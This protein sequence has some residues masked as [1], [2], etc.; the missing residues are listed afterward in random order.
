MP[1]KP[2]ADP[3]NESETQVRV[4][5]T[6]LVCKCPDGIWRRIKVDNDGCFVMAGEGQGGGAVTVQNW[7]ASY[8][9]NNW[10]TGFVV[11]G[12]VAVSNFPASFQVSNFPA[13]QAVTGTFWPAT[14]PVS[15]TFWQATQ[16]VSGPLTDAQLRAAAVPVSGTFWPATQPVSGTFWQATQ[17]VSIAASVAVT[18]TFWQATQPVSGPLTDA[19]LRAAAVP[20]SGAFFQATQPVSAAALPLPTGAAQDRPSSLCVTGTAASGSGVTITLPNVAGQFHYI[21]SI[22]ISAYNVAARTGGAT[23]VVCTTTNIPGSLAFTF[24]SA[25]A[26]GTTESQQVELGG[27]PLKSSVANTTTTIVCPATSNVIWRVTAFYQAAA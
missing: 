1:L 7:P 13:T 22:R 15:G 9:I 23:P 20:V 18:G 8:A 6:V 3:I 26:I 5:E 16:P 4:T 24:G 10:P 14:Q 27:N 12:T 2:L 21:S 17:P 11:S 19:Q 25:G